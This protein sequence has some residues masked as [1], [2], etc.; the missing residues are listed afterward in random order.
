MKRVPILFQL[1][2]VVQGPGF[3]ALVRVEGRAVMTFEDEEWHCDGVEP[4]GLTRAGDSPFAAFG[5]FKVAF[6]HVLDDLAGDAVSLEDFERDARSFFQTNRLEEVDWQTARLE[7]PADHELAEP[8]RGLQ[9]REPGA[10]TLSIELLSNLGH[11][12]LDTSTDSTIVALP[13]AA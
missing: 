2:H 13:I 7:M 11:E 8:F 9:R 6:R 10:S 4:G 12:P 3:D 1:S 5:R